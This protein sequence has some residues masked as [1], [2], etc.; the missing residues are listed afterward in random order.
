MRFYFGIL[1][2]ILTFSSCFESDVSKANRIIAVKN[3]NR[4]TPNAEFYKDQEDSTLFNLFLR[5]DDEEGGILELLT[6]QNISLQ[7][8]LQKIYPYTSRD[9]I[10]RVESYFIEYVDGHVPKGRY[11]VDSTYQNNQIKFLTF[12]D[13]KVSGSFNIKFISNNTEK[14]KYESIIVQCE[15]FELLILIP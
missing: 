8:D 9:Q 15:N 10:N 3:G 4:W 14:S 11:Y 1:F 6:L 13:S 7:L 5:I 12:N 2:I